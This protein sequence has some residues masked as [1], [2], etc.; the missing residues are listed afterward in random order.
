MV[1]HLNRYTPSFLS[2][3]K[4]SSGRNIFVQHDPVCTYLYI[5]KY[6]KTYKFLLPAMNPDLLYSISIYKQCHL[7][8]GKLFTNGSPLSVWKTLPTKLFCPYESWKLIWMLVCIFLKARQEHLISLAW[9]MRWSTGL[10]FPGNWKLEI[11][12]SKIYFKIF[13]IINKVWQVSIALLNDFA[14]GSRIIILNYGG[15]LHLGLLG[16]VRLLPLQ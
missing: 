11:L 7:Q 1:C 4:W 3:W 2:F 16:E 13:W 8:P 15:T 14:W 5:I 12:F 6:L 10:Y 9:I